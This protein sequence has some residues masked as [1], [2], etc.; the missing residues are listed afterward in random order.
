M[1]YTLMCPYVFI[2]DRYYKSEQFLD[3]Y[4]IFVQAM[5]KGIIFKL[6]SNLIV[7]MSSHEVVFK[8]R[9]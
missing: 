7:L 9:E 5:S 3:N 2:Q 8:E 1:T 6:C 4:Q